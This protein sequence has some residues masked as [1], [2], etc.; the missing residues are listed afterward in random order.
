MDR[1]QCRRWRAEDAKHEESSRPNPD[2]DGGFGENGM[3]KEI[4]GNGWENEFGET[5][6]GKRDRALPSPPRAGTRPTAL[7]LP[8]PARPAPGRGGSATT[9]AASMAAEISP[10][11]PAHGMQVHHGAVGC[12]HGIQ[13]H[14]ALQIGFPRR[15]RIYRLNFA[16]QQPLHHLGRNPGGRRMGMHVLSL[17]CGFQLPPPPMPLPGGHGRNYQ[18]QGQRDHQK[19]TQRWIRHPAS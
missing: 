14:H 6:L 4:W 13:H 12:D 2:A 18:Q 9:V 1:G 5:G 7:S 8:Q 10:S 15:F 11:G 16:N 3:G 17:P 19:P